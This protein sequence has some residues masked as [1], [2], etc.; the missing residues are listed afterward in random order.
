MLEELSSEQ[1][2]DELFARSP[3]LLEKLAAVAIAVDGA[4]RPNRAP[5]A[6]AVPNFRTTLLM[7]SPAGSSGVCYCS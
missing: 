2:W 7:P 3:E 5:S 1:R 6:L 4:G